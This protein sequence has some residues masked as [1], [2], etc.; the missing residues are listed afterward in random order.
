[1]RQELG[2]NHCYDDKN[3]NNADNPSDY[4]KDEIA[5]QIRVERQMRWHSDTSV[6]F[7]NDFVNSHQEVTFGQLREILVFLRNLNF[8]LCLHKIAIEI[9]DV[10]F[11]RALYN[12][13]RIT[14]RHLCIPEVSNRLSQILVSNSDIAGVGNAIKRNNEIL[15]DNEVGI[16]VLEPDDGA[17]N[18]NEDEGNNES[19]CGTLTNVVVFHS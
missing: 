8:R 13:R 15:L 12:V 3:P 7:R 10:V 1:M 4:I 18:K 19:A 14:A 5:A 17:S 9:A 16:E 2:F 6:L 11:L